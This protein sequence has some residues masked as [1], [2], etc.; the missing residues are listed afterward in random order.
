MTSAAMTVPS[1]FPSA[2]TTAAG[3]LNLPG[4]SLGNYSLA[5]EV[6]SEP[7]EDGYSFENPKNVKKGSV[8]QEQEE[9]ST[10][11]LGHKKPTYEIRDDASLKLVSRASQKAAIFLVFKFIVFFY[12]YSF[13]FL[14]Y[15][16][17]LFSIF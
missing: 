12:F 3:D 9:G 10:A 5:V 17:F 8:R 4:S 7:R 15:P 16:L 14:F 11:A 6:N 2:L 13:V 1:T